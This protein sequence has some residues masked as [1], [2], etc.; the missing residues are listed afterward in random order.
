MVNVPKDGGQIY[1]NPR[2]RQLWIIIF[3][4][5]PYFQSREKAARDHTAEKCV[6]NTAG[7][8]INN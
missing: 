8:P 7:F 4:L 3:L 1:E 5:F 2:K 6:R